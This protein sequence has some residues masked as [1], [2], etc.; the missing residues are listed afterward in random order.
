[1]EQLSFGDFIPHHCL[2]YCEEHCWIQVPGANQSRRGGW[3]CA[4][5]AL[6]FNFRHYNVY[7]SF[8]NIIHL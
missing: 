4:S 8:E 1:M 2:V 3:L 7:V 6:P 5:S